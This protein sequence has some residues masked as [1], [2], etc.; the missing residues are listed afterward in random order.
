LVS[1]DEFYD[2]QAN[3]VWAL[4]ILLLKM[5]GTIHPFGNDPDDTIEVLKNRIVY[6]PLLIPW[7]SADWYH[8][9]PAVLV[10]SILQKDPNK[11]L[12]VSYGFVYQT[13]TS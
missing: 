12:T 6:E 11:R 4:G 13:D 3:D 8:G 5:L 1:Q 7:K 10:E 2:P 9:G